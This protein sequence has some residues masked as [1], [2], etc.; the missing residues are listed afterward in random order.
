MRGYGRGIDTCIGKFD[1]S[2]IL[3]FGCCS[4]EFGKDRG[5]EGDGTQNEFGVDRQNVHHLRHTQDGGMRVIEAGRKKLRL[6]NGI[7]YYAVIMSERDEETRKKTYGYKIF[8]ISLG[9]S[10]EQCEAQGFATESEAVADARREL[11]ICQTYS[12]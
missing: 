4:V 10:A 9:G 1:V 12:E 5:K 11:E 2:D 6:V 3:I 7:G 8:C